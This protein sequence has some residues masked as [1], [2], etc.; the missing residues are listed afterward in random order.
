MGGGAAI[1][2]M[3][4]SLKMNKRSRVKFF[5]QDNNSLDLYTKPLV[6]K[7][8]SDEEKLSAKEEMERLQSLE[9]IRTVIAI[10][11]TL[12]IFGIMVIKLM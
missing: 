2:N 10:V 6:L 12:V 8:A 5:K 4:A 9:N 11:V 1:A 7:E 3:I